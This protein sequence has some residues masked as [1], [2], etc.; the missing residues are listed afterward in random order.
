MLQAGGQR[1]RGLIP[2]RGK[3]FLTS[4]YRPDR[5]RDSPSRQYSGQRG[6]FPICKAAG[7]RSGEAVPP[8]SQEVGSFQETS[9][10]VVQFPCFLDQ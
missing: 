8:K 7:T 3:R 10:L 5:L 1:R 2:A 6:H 4:T 9:L